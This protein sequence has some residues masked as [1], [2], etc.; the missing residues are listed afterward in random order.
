MYSAAELKDLSMKPRINDISLKVL[1][2]YYEMYLYPFIYH[3]HV[4]VDS[5]EKEIE[6]RFEKEN[7][8]HLLG[9]ESTVK[10]A[11]PIKQL[12]NYRGQA[13]WN[14]VINEVFDIQSLKQINKKKFNNMK[15][16]YVYFYLLPALVASPLAVKYD[17][18]RVNPKTTIDCEILFYSQV[19]DDT[20]IIHLGLEKH[21][22]GHYFP[23]TF[24]MERVSQKEQD[25]YIRQQEPIYVNVKNR[26]ILLSE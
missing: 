20:A 11:V 7:F 22:Q 5:Q 2:E 3:Y 10:Y 25:I 23:K 13:G 12:H 21:E 14:N 8:C 4:R 15:A 16:K 24:F 6:L 19:K 1:S 18:K 17:I 26:V 9:I